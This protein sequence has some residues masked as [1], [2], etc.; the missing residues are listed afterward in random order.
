MRSNDIIYGPLGGRMRLFTSNGI[1]I[2]GDVTSNLGA[3]DAGTEVNE[4]PRTG[5]N[6]ALN[7][8]W[9]NAG[10]AENLEVRPRTMALPIH[11]PPR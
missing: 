11:R 9:L 7:Q 5:P 10:D 3:F 8:Q 2:T 6:V 1:L 4:D